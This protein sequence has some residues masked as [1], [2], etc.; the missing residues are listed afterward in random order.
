VRSSQ[1]WSRR[2]KSVD[3]GPVTPLDLIGS[4]PPRILTWSGYGG[5]VAGDSISESDVTFGLIVSQSTTSQGQQPT[6]AGTGAGTGT[7]T[8]MRWRA[9]GR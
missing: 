6:G 4:Q 9:V 2:S 1:N 7:G 3:Y 5:D 8:G